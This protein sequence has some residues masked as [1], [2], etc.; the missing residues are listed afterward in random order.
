MAVLGS[1][2]SLGGPDPDA[3]G[4]REDARAGRDSARRLAVLIVCAVPLHPG[5][6]HAQTLLTQQEALALAFPEPAR[7]ERRTAFLEEEELARAREAAEGAEVESRIVTYYVGS[8]EGRVL[9]YAYFDAHRVRT[10]DEVVMVVVT[11]SG[12]IDRIEV[13]RFAEPREYLAPD[14]WLEQFEGRGL[15]D[16]LSTKGE[17]VNITGATLTARAIARAARRTLAL[18]GV[19]H[20]DPAP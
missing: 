17:I 7:I 12:T 18:H 4:R 19:I 10:L 14:R 20:G 11:P 9:G 1:R 2:S 3:S 5:V 16:R 6:G 8:L 15:G 13:L